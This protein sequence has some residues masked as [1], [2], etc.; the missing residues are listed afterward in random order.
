M[1]VC[2]G[3]PPIG[4]NAVAVFGPLPAGT[5]TYEIYVLRPGEPEE[6]R[7]TQILIVASAPDLNLPVL[8]PVA[9]AVLLAALALGG[10]YVLARH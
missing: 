6:F 4:L 7:S 1:P 2:Q 10:V 5:C 9:L 3:F 8:S